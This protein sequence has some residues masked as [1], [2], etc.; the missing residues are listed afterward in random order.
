MDWLIGLPL[1]IQ[2]AATL[3]L[4]VP[5]AGVGAWVLLWVLDTGIRMATTRRGKRRDHD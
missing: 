1:W 5:V 4:L 3:G 2:L